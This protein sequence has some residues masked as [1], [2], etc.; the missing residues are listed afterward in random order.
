MNPPTIS[1]IVPCFNSRAYVAEAL[2]SI[3]A[4]THR[5]IEVIVAD[6]GSTDGTLEAARQYSEVVLVTQPER[7]PA[8]TRNLGL[9]RATGELVAFLD[10]DDLWHPD[11]LT[12]QYQCF[13]D[14]PEIQYCV[15]HA[16]MFWSADLEGERDRLAD[17]PRS[18]AVPGYATTT[19]LARRSLFD[20]IGLFDEGLRFGDAVEWFIRASERNVEMKLLD[21]VLTYHRMHDSNLT[22]RLSRESRE[23]FL[24]IVRGVLRRRSGRHPNS[25]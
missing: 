15:S 2:D 25:A 11:K 6:D 17:H 10:A 13:V 21:E 23:E 12:R 1:C 8:A 7:G 24:G 14:D 16:R 19:L 22:R 20:R 4:Q 5:P 18:R 9:R 3:F